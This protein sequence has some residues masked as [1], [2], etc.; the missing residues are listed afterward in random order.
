MLRTFGELLALV[1]N[2]RLSWK[3]HANTPA[4][5]VSEYVSQVTNIKLW[6]EK[7]IFCHTVSEDEKNVL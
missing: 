2:I 5:F 4:Y 7:N 3:K 1:T 6:P